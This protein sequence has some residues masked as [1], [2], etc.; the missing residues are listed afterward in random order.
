MTEEEDK[1]YWELHI[2]CNECEH[3]WYCEIPKEQRVKPCKDYQMA[4]DLWEFLHHRKYGY[5]GGL[6]HECFT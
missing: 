3:N 1:R 6:S 2:Q 5:H 4:H